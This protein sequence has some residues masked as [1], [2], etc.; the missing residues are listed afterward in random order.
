[1]TATRASTRDKND[2]SGTMTRS[3]RPN[4]P[5]GPA[6]SVTEHVTPPGANIFLDLGSAPGEAECLRVRTLLMNELRRII[7]DVP[8][9]PAAKIFGVDQSVVTGLMKGRI[10]LFTIDAL[11]S[12]LGRVGAQ[13]NIQVALPPR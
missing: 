13:V 8:K 10:D 3:G 5:S 11:V 6:R 4:R 12:M 9:R 1:M 2:G 7:G